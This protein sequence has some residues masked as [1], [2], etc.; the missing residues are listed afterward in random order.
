MEKGSVLVV[1]KS[2]IDLLVPYHTAITGGYVDQL[3]PEGVSNQIVGK[4]SSALEAG[5]CPSVAIRQNNVQ[6]C[7]SNSLDLVGSLWYNSLNCFF[8]VVR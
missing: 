3:N 2:I 8:I 6:S 4:D 7:N 1:L 5:V